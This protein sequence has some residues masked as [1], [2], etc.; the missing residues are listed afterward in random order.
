MKVAIKVRKVKEKL[1][2]RNI[3]QNSFAKKLKI[4]SGYMSQL[5]SGTRNPSAKLRKKILKELKLDEDHFDDI[6]RLKG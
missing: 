2:R 1:A 4:T 3:S 6:F 5:F